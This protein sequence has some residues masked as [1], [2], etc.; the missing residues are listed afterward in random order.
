MRDTAAR[1]PVVKPTST[2][3][4][5]G[6]QVTCPRGQA[7]H[8]GREP[9]LC[10]PGRA[11][12]PPHGPRRGAPAARRG[13]CLHPAGRR[14]EGPCPPRGGHVLHPPHGPRRGARTTRQGPCPA[15]ADRDV[16]PDG[17]PAGLPPGRRNLAA[18]VAA[19]VNVGGWSCRWRCRWRMRA[20]AREA[21]ATDSIAGS[22]GQA[23]PALRPASTGRVQ[24]GSCRPRG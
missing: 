15:P 9:A 5:P 12:H 17:S 20:G 16:A 4:G 6:R 18:G 8:G 2:K 3:F 22:S 14:Q 23:P 21:D 7:A 10:H 19:G 1:D 11:L 13:S 24:T